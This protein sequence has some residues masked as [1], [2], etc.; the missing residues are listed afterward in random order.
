LTII[1]TQAG[2]GIPPGTLAAFQSCWL[3]FEVAA[4]PWQTE[5]M[6]I[7]INFRHRSGWSIHCLAPDCKT[8][9]S[10][11]LTVQEDETLLRVLAASGATPAQLDEVVK[12]MRRWGRGST[13]IDINDAGRRL[14]R[15]K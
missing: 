11:W 8:L 15:I 7:L 6:R 1:N 12:D 13:F 3:A 4:S 9:V 5:P 2:K 10:P 14:L